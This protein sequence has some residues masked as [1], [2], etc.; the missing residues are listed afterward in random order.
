MRAWAAG[1]PW[2]ASWAVCHAASASLRVSAG[3]RLTSSVCSWRWRTRSNSVSAGRRSAAISLTAGGTGAFTL[4]TPVRRA[5]I[6]KALTLF[7]QFVEQPEGNDDDD[8]ERDEWACEPEG[9]GERAE[10]CI[11]DFDRE[12]DDDQREGDF[13]QRVRVERAACAGHGRGCVTTTKSLPTSM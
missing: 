10:E 9:G 7:L 11:E 6:V 1:A 3:T 5:W 2:R 12:P 8:H 13:H 4:Y